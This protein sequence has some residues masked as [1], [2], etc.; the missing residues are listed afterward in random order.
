[1][2]TVRVLFIAHLAAL[3]F[4]I[5]GI[6]VFMRNPALLLSNPLIL[7]SYPLGT[8]FGGIIYILLGAAAMIVYGLRYVGVRK[9]LIFLPIAT[10]LPLTAE[11]I[12]TS[13]GYPF[14][15][16]EYTELLGYKILGLVPFTIPLS[17]FYMGFTSYLL[18]TVIIS[19]TRLRRQ[20]LWSLALG[21]WFLTAW[22][23]ALDPAMVRNPVFP[24]WVWYTKG[25]YYGMPIQNFVGWSLVG[26]T[27]M[28]ISRYFWRAN[29]DASKLPTWLPFGMY[30]A[31][32]VFAMALSASAGLWE[33]LIFAVV[34]GLAP[35]SLA[36]W[37][38][39]PDPSGG[40]GGPNS[41][42]RRGAPGKVN[43]LFEGIAQATIAI[44]S[45]LLLARSVEV[46]VEGLANVPK[47][48]AVLIPSRHYHHLFDGAIFMTRLRRPVHILVALDWARTRRVRAIMEWA[49]HMAAWPGVL[50]TDAFNVGRGQYDDR[51][52]YRIN[53]AGRYLRQAAT[54]SVDAL[55]SGEIMVVFPEAYPN[56]DPEGSP[57]ADENTFLPFE[58]G[59]VKLAQLA[60]R[61]GQTTVSIVPAGFTSQTLPNGR[62][63]ITVR[64]GA[65]LLLA[66]YP[67]RAQLVAYVEREVKALSASAPAYQ[68]APQSAGARQPAQA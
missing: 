45:A 8:Q 40:A 20:T 51:H 31:N 44:G 3:A 24:F 23:L 55:R 29:A 17:W 34:C 32:M 60:E 11:L 10:L 53:E 50:R 14:G 58:P 67:D 26:L 47:R 37:L 4:A 41:G 25:V 16:Y 35:A 46:A 38:R 57:K 30:A 6:L 59:F 15:S 48:G 39:R 42:G 62:Q 68:P 43:P 61:D 19:A 21:A 33:P 65:P 66:D 27:F 54:A 5:T 36:L 18:A 22:D 49:C 13:T 2:R 1:M 12:G 28:G 9:T 7:K 63:R 56:I 52:A 64:F